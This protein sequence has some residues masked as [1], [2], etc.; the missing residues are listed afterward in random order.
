MKRIFEE[1]R[2]LDFGASAVAPITACYLGACG[3]TVIR[4]E[5]RTHVDPLRTFGPYKNDVVGVDN[6]AQYTNYNYNKYSV[7]LNLEHPRG[8]ELAYE[9]VRW[10]D[11]VC[12]GHAPGSMKKLGFDYETLSKIKPDI[13][14]L[15][16]S[17]LGQYGPECQQRGYGTQLTAYC[18]FTD[19]CGWPDQS[20]SVPFG[21]IT[22]F[23]SARL[24]TCGLIAAMIYRKRTGKGTFMDLSQLEASLQVLS[25]LLLDYSVNRRTNSRR[26]NQ[27]S[28]CAPHGVYPCMGDDDWC[29]IAIGIA[30]ADNEWEQFC[31]V[32]DS[33][34]WIDDP[35]FATP[36]ARKQNESEL[37]R[38]IEEKTKKI[39]SRELME[40]LQS[41]GIAAGVLHNAQ[42]VHEDPQLKFRHHFWLLDHPVIGKHSYDGPAF[43][44]SKTP[45][46]LNKAAP[47]LGEDNEYVCTKILGLSDEELVDLYTQG[48]LE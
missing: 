40:K 9:L 13:I 23:L 33:P 10:A 16:T 36:L 14:M 11:I 45:V 48:A 42:G 43:R 32:L 22:D 24:S 2:V 3:A 46:M 28:H 8:K 5:S 34:Q 41:A 47:C 15:S 19:L 30:D 26:G 27:S 4:L 12:E 1:T 35:R 44:L 25:P 31:R 39:Y 17:N 37:D 38:L 7:T 6:S 21:A 18:G 20:P 29:A